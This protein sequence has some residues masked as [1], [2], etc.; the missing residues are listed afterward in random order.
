MSLSD[1]AIRKTKPTDK[2][3]KLTEGKG[4]YLLLN[5]NGSRWWRFDYRRPITGKRNTLSFGTYP[6][7]GLADARNKRDAARKLLADGVDPGEHRKAK[8]LAGQERAANSFEVVARE[9]FAK[10]EPN[11]APATRQRF[12]SASRTTCSRGSGRD[13][14][15]T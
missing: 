3:I 13:L 2:P 9:W 1:T 12:C 4:L 7:T 8:E 6:D 14:S 5:P 10:Q 11:W 15:A